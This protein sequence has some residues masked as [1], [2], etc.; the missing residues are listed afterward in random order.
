MSVASRPDWRDGTA[1]TRMFHG[2]IEPDAKLP[3]S[4]GVAIRKK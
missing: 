1:I 3:A 2:E 4:P